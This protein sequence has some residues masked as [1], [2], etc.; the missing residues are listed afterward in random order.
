MKH[1]WRR[2]R[3]DHKLSDLKGTA[4]S[5]SYSGKKILWPKRPCGFE[6]RPRH[7]HVINLVYTMFS[8]CGVSWCLQI[9]NNRHQGAIKGQE[10][11]TRTR[12]KNKG[13]EQGTRTRD[14]NKQSSGISPSTSK[15]KSPVLR[16][17]SIHTRLQQLRLSFSQPKFSRSKFDPGV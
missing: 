14:K 2:H 5:E 1:A 10:Q 3:P 16:Q 6:S 4:D 7:C 11:G 17:N 12:D 13:Q 8:I 15:S 9:R